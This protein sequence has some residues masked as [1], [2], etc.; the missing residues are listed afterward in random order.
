MKVG[1]DLAAHDLAAGVLDALSRV[2][3][4]NDELRIPDYRGHVE[5]RVGRD[6]QGAVK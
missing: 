6:Y 4:V 1:N 2:S 3:C 5:G